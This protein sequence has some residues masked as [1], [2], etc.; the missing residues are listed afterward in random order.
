M[1]IEHLFVES[2]NLGIAVIE[3][4]DLIVGL[5]L[6]THDGGTD[7]SEP[8]TVAPALAVQDEAGVLS[9]HLEGGT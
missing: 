5:A 7:L 6:L 1:N 9:F 2:F 3:E 4:E 8:H